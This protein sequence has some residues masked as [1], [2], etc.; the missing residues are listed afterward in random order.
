MGLP[1]QGRVLHWHGPTPLPILLHIYPGDTGRAH[2]KNSRVFPHNGA[3][4]AMSS[5]DAATDVA[6][7]LSNTLANPAP[8]SPF[9]CFGTQTMDSIWKLADIFAATG[10]PTPTPTPPPRRTR[11]TTPLPTL[12]GNDDHHTPP[13]VPP[14]VPPGLPPRPPP[15]HNRGWSHQLSTHPTGTPCAH[16]HEPTIRWRP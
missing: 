9:A 1:W 8:A 13:R 4:P 5:A 15:H 16:T 14:T 2:S 7:R 10:A 11:K 6:R 12:Q 3:M